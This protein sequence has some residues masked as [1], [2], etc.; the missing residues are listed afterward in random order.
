MK[1]II[2]VLATISLLLIG[3]S[4]GSSGRCKGKGGWYGDRNLTQISPAKLPMMVH[5]E[6]IDPC[7]P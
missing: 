6:A 4:C 5:K 2:P 7:I 1:K 3:S